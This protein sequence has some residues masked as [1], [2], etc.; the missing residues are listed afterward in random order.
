MEEQEKLLS[1]CEDKKAKLWKSYQNYLNPR[2]K[3]EHTNNHNIYWRPA[4][5]KPSLESSPDYHDPHNMHNMQSLNNI[6]KNNIIS[7]MSLSRKAVDGKQTAPELKKGIKF[8]SNVESSM[9]FQEERFNK[10][11]LIR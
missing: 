5:S 11:E 6:T 4:A 9:I 1:K 2:V 7:H 8:S 3:L 10:G